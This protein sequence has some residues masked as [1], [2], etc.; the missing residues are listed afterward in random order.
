MFSKSRFSLRRPKWKKKQDGATKVESGLSNLPTELKQRVASFL[1]LRD[2]MN[3]VETSKSMASDLDIT[4][5]SSPL[6]DRSSQN[7]SYLTGGVAACFA[8]VVP[9]QEA[10]LPHSMMTFCCDI[11]HSD[12][13]IWIK[14]QDIPINRSPNDLESLSSSGKLVSSHNSRDGRKVSMSF[15]PQPGKFYQF[16]IKSHRYYDDDI[17][18]LANMVLHRTGWGIKP[19]GYTAFQYDVLR[20]SRFML[21]A[22]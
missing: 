5:A 13:A 6:T 10:S 8:A 2:L 14:E 9:N 17:V 15:C 3:L 7:R 11:M 21:M 18:G 22:K 1:T 4:M 20:R 19:M 12:G 16:W